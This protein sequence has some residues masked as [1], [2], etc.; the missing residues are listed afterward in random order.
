M[1]KTKSN[2]EELFGETSLVAWKNRLDGGEVPSLAQIADIIEANK[3]EPLPDWFVEH[4]CKRLRHPD[5]PKIGRPKSTK[6]DTIDMFAAFMYQL[7]LK[8]FQEERKF[9]LPRGQRRQKAG[10][11]PSERAARLVQGNLYKHKDWKAVLNQISSQK[12][13]RL[14]MNE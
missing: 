9:G 10:Q 4:L 7:L 1:T 13:P 3:D 5:K 12:W 14:F 11:P 2:V 6:S 8:E